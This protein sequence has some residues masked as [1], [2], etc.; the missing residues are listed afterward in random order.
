MKQVTAFC[1]GLKAIFGF[2]I[3]VQSKC[4]TIEIGTCPNYIS[5]VKIY[6]SLIVHMLS[7]ANNPIPCSNPLKSQQG[8]LVNIALTG[9]NI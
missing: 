2:L 9:S 3:M 4:H 8:T 1:F 6:F 7:A 5:F